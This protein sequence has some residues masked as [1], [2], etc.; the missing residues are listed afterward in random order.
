MTRSESSLI[1]RPAAGYAAAPVVR[2]AQLA[3][4]DLLGLMAVHG[5]AGIEELKLLIAWPA[6]IPDAYQAWMSSMTAVVNA[7][8]HSEGVRDMG[9]LSERDKVLLTERAYDLVMSSPLEEKR[10]G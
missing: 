1:A 2:S 6:G 10:A 3:T 7:L 8:G 5:I 4:L 9:A